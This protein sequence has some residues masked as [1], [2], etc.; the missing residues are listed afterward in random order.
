MHAPRPDPKSVAGKELHV[1]E[2]TQLLVVGAGPAGL[3]A[4]IE[5]ARLGL[6]VVVVDENPV[7]AETMGLEVPLHFGQRM[8]GAT[9]NRNAML[10]AIVTSAPAIAD[11]FEAGVDVRLG[12]EVWGLYANGPSVGW[13]P[14]PVAGLADGERS[15]LI[16]CDR[17]IVAAGRRDMGLAFPGWELPG[18]MGATAAQRLAER[19][20]ALEARRAVVLGTSAEA[21]A[22]ATA[23][24]RAGIDI[25]AVVEHAPAAIGPADLV[26]VVTDAGIPV[27]TGHV[28]R[29]AEGGADGVEALVLA[30]VDAEGSPVLGTESR[31]DCNAV[32]LGVAAVPVIELLDALGCRIA[33]QPERGGHVP[34]LDAAQ[35]TSI[36]FVYAVGDCA[37][38]WP[39][40]TL[41]PAVAEAE[42]RRAA[43]HVA[44]SLGAGAADAAVEAEALPRPDKPSHDLCAYRLGWVR[45][46]VV[47]ACGEPHVCQCEE[48]TAR[49]ILDVR[50]PRYLGW[51]DSKRNSRDLRSLLGEGPPNP[52]QVKRLT[53]AGMGSC[54][55][56]R[57]REQ[58]AALLALGAGVPLSEVPLAT[59]RAPVRPLPLA[60]A[61]DAQ[62]PVEMA[63]HW[64]TGFGM[65]SQYLPYWEVGAFY[66]VADG[67]RDGP[68][69]SE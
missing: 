32:V 65:P 45:A 61:G 28:V 54:Q 36:G 26:S 57:C 29:Q 14:G 20:G 39:S 40:K 56:R 9:R 17:V 60:V 47:E 10:E 22:A 8:C 55:G 50:P 5:A 6:Q 31:I 4:A 1:A 24:R 33:F 13:L 58:V 37:G 42:G 30:R 3:A 62:E 51:P 69:A 68:V 15:W 19:Y 66:T 12:T 25:A 64:D 63:E 46:S 44:A 2:R 34:V 7:P 35:R 67:R 23:L 18:V 49:E 27:L 53:R 11:A 38:I 43:A 41:D 16:G 52:D 21:L 59:H 48:V